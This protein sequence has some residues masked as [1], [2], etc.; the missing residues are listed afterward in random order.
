MV[1]VVI[2]WQWAVGTQLITFAVRSQRLNSVDLQ[3]PRRLS[4]HLGRRR[5]DGEPLL[6]RFPH[7]HSVDLNHQNDHM[8]S[9]KGHTRTLFAVCSISS[10]L[11]AVVGHTPFP[12]LSAAALRHASRSW[13]HTP[14][15]AGH[16]R[17]YCI[18]YTHQ[19][20]ACHVFVRF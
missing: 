1:N 20:S 18:V 14:T 3:V 15:C 10:L 8:I 13:E 12:T 2:R 4:K 5:R 16:N 6:V 7:L 9:C 19:S 17:M 11:S